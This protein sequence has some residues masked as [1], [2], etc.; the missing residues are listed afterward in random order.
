MGETLDISGAAIIP[1]G[2]PEAGYTGLGEED[3][4]AIF[5]PLLTLPQVPLRQE[6]DE[7]DL[8]DIEGLDPQIAER[9][10]EKGE[11]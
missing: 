8:T 5:K 4:P 10:Q 2:N 6:E 3:V 1:E 9:I 11:R 7:L